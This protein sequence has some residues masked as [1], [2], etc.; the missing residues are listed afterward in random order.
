MKSH[1]HTGLVLLTV[2]M[3]ATMAFGANPD[4]LG[5][6]KLDEGSGTTV[7]DLSGNGNDGTLGG[8]PTWVDDA[9][10]GAVLSFD[11]NN[12]YIATDVRIPHMTLENGFTWVFWCKQAGDG[13]GV[14]ETAF[15]NR[16]GGTQ[17]P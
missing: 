14:N 7:T 3:L 2:L 13:T 4:L 11:G 17:N 1:N 5:H 8:A 6:W 10:H 9:V 15:G 16:N 12:D